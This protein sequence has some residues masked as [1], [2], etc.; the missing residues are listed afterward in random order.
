[1]AL[2]DNSIGQFTFIALL[3]NPLPP[4]QVVVPDDRPGVNGTEFVLLGLKGEPFS[5]I[6]H[7]DAADYEQAKAI[8]AEYQTLQQEDAVELAQGGVS[9]LDAAYRVKVL[10][11]V[12]IDCRSIRGGSGYR[13]A[14][15]GT[16]YLVCRWDLVAVPVEEATA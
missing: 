3:G 16:G 1:M 6:S 2:T 14:S 7:R 8:F 10:R 15:N 13:F 9:S 4:S 5:L 12:Q 11:V